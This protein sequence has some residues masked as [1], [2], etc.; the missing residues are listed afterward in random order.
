[1]VLRRKNSE[2]KTPLFAY[3]LLE[4][5]IPPKRIRIKI[6]VGKCSIIRKKISF[7]YHLRTFAL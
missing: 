2:F 6:F 1:M 4:C 7:F 3:K 5:K